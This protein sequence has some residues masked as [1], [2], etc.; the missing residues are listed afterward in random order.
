MSESGQEEQQQSETKDLEFHSRSKRN[1]IEWWKMES[2]ND[3]DNLKKRLLL[4]DIDNITQVSQ[5]FLI[6]E[7]LFCQKNHFTH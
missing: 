4:L 3:N 6:F 5:S 1:L 7:I 2:K